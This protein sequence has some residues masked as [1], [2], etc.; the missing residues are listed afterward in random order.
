MLRIQRYIT[1]PTVMLGFALGIGMPAN[2]Q[3][4]LIDGSTP[5]LVNGENG[6]SGT[7]TVTGGALSGDNLFHNFTHFGVDSN[8]TVTFDDPGVQ[9]I[10]TRVTGSDTSLIDGVLSTSPNSSADLFV[11]NPNGIR[12]GDGASL[13]VGGSFFASTASDITFADGNQV[14]IGGSPDI[15]TVSVP[16]GLQ[17]GENPGSIMADSA[18]LTVPFGETIALV[19]G[20]ISLN[21]STLT[22]AS[23]QVLLGGVGSNASV[24]LDQNAGDIT[25]DYSQTE[26]FSN[27]DLTNGTTVSVTGPDAGIIQLQG[28]QLTLSQ[29]SNL[30][31]FTADAGGGE[32]QLRGTE[33]IRMTDAGTEAL[34][35]ILPPAEG[36][37]SDLVTVETPELTLFAGAQ[38]G[39]TMV[40]SGDAGQVQVTA[41]SVLIDDGS[42]F[43]PSAIFSTVEGPGSGQGGELIVNTDHLRISNGGSLVAST[44]APGDAGDLIVTA[45]TIE[46]DG[47]NPRG[48]SL[49]GSASEA[50]PFAVTGLSPEIPP[51]GSG[52]GGNIILETDRLSVVNGGQVTVGTNSNNPAGSLSITATESVNLQG[53]VS[54]GRS[55]LFA[56]ARVGS[57]DG[58][59]ISVTTDQLRLEDG[60]TINVSNASSSALSQVPQGSGSAGNIDIIANDVLLNSDSVITADTLNGDRANIAIQSETL[61]LQDSS[62]TTDATGTATGGNITITSSVLSLLDDSDIAA[63][64]L[65]NFGGQVTINSQRLL[66][67]PES[68]ITATSA[69]GAEFNGVVELNTP[70]VP[71]EQVQQQE[72]NPTETKQIV[73]AC[74]QLTENELVV[75]G[76]G[77]LPADPTQILMGS[78]VWTDIR[79]GS[80]MIE[81]RSSELSSETEAQ[82]GINEAQGLARNA[83][84]QLTLVAQT[85][86]FSDLTLASG[87]QTSLCR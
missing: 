47:F 17:M 72:E 29:A 43:G 49:I 10:I 75:T 80:T 34:S 16:T 81:S 42:D 30:H 37:G 24:L 32:I 39:L 26:A 45:G 7:C 77:G 61:T 66:Q 3:T 76:R 74:E 60:A 85:G 57:G 51:D 14:G 78:S 48:A 38:I 20:D 41:G 52:I 36:N 86:S 54:N 18:T 23:G 19:G 67:S 82:A 59:N 2:S 87:H 33:A 58:G 69:L 22:A 31:A 21:G 40:G 84:G 46:V 64:A 63:N 55:G 13:Q 53:Q 27:I 15:L 83:E 56:S 79:G 71:T 9:N 12:F 65:F 1:Y 5:T 44:F 4:I 35:A 50:P 62:I 68:S 73:A 28:A 25:L 8:A 11:F 70:D 6:C